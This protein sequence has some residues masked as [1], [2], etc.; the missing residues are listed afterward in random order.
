VKKLFGA[1]GIRGKVDQY[2][3]QPDDLVRFGRCLA[4]RWFD[5]CP[6]PTILLGTDTREASQR[7]KIALVDGL[8]RGGVKVLDGNILP[9]AAVSNLVAQLPDV[10]GGIAITA[11]HNPIIEDGIKVFNQNGCKLK[12]EEEAE[13]E[14]LFFDDNS[15]LP[16]TIRPAEF[17][18]MSDASQRY[19]TALAHEFMEI[20]RC[21]RRL[22]IDCANGASYHVVQVLFSKLDLRTVYLN[23]SPDG[24]N[25]NRN[26]GSEYIRRQP[27]HLFNEMQRHKAD[28]G[29]ALD[30]DADRV[31]MMDQE[32]HFYDGDMLLAIL[33]FHLQD[34]Q[35][36]KRN[37]VVITQM[38][39]SGLVGHLRTNG[40]Q[41]D[42]VRNGD[43]YITN[44]LMEQGYIL[45][46]EQNGHLIIQAN[47]QRVTGDGLH[48]TLWVL[49]ALAQHPGVSLNELTYRLRKWPQVNISAGLGD[50][51]FQRASDI[52]GLESLKEQVHR[53]VPDLSRF[54]CRPAS[55]EPVYRI[56]LEAEHTPIEQLTV[57]AFRLAKHVQKEL[58]K[59]DEP[60]EILD[61]VNGGLINHPA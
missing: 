51:I 4:A 23:V 31:V 37:T 2:P 24:T 38:S 11:S 14:R 61:C 22:L 48:T 42:Q 5:C 60:I 45:G 8:I 13:L 35:T 21:P 40:I 19:A 56:M 58:G 54:E 17:R 15:L 7:I 32:G 36:L 41:V 3:F 55:T 33:A 46:G 1:D 34:Q 30:G 47:P 39:N 29:I 9:T 18:E 20:E 26:A 25:I 43:K 28:L 53:Q 27:A 10:S 12:D 59:L 6:S 50:R 16:S 49:K 52:S 57:H 44:R